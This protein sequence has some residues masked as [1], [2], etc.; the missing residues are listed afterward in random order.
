MHCADARRRPQKLLADGSSRAEEPLEAADVD[1]YE[2][3]GVAFV[4]G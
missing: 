3:I 2:V 1:R 4:P